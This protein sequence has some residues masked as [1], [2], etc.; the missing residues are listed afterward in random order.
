MVLEQ[1]AAANAVYVI[2]RPL[3]QMLGRGRTGSSF[4]GIPVIALPVHVCS[5][6]RFIDVLR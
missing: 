2:L 4:T 1:G 5:H 3:L 6:I